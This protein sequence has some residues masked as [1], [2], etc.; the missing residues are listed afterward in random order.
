MSKCEHC[1]YDGEHF[2]EEL[3]IDRETYERRAND[4]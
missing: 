4:L 1:G 3:R 2:E